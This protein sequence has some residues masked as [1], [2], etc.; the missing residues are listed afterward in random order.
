VTERPRIAYLSYSTGQFDARTHRMARS[1]EAAGYRVTVYA[2][3]EPGLPLREELGGYSLVRVPSDWRLGVPGFHARGRRRV[4]R[5]VRRAERAAAEGRRSASEPH[6]TSHEHTSDPTPPVEPVSS[7]LP[8]WIPARLRGTFLSPYL[9]AAKARSRDLPRP[10]TLISFPLRPLGWAAAVVAVA[11]PADIWH[12]MWA[13]SLPALE[14]LSRKFGGRTIYDS[15]DVFMHSRDFAHIGRVRRSALL[16]MERRWAQHADAVLTVNEAYA[17]LLGPLLRIPSPQIVMNCPERWIPPTPRPNRIR[18][19]LGIPPATSIVLYQG[20]LTTD[21]GI[22]QTME[23]LLQVPDAALVLMG[24][25]KTRAHLEQQSLKPP[26]AGRV[27]L[28]PAVPP[29]DLLEWTAS[30]DIVVVAI[31]PTSLNHH[32]TTPQKLFEALAAGVPVVAADLPGI[33]E[34]V[35]STDAG[36]LC[37]PTSP[38]AIAMALRRVLDAPADDIEAL[39]ARSLAAAHDRYNWESQVGTLLAVYE[40]L[41]APHLRSNPRRSTT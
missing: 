37:D 16:A 10:K 41:L 29:D 18:E 34:V 3:W 5:A 26:Y 38:D 8:R 7:T 12:G 33:A 31:Q 25:G 9:R 17:E 19:A 39:R 1:A 22:E 11:E 35:T 30:A 32:F 13:G 21:R 6:P 15:R 24:Y 27:F 20:N 28:L 36:V 2:R 14:R 23:A 4:A 40:G